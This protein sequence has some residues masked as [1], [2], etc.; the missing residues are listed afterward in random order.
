MSVHAVDHARGNQH[1]QALS[2]AA[3]KVGSHTKAHVP[4]HEPAEIDAPTSGALPDDTAPTA[5]EAEKMPGVVRLLEAGHFKGVADVRLRINF[6]DELSARA[7]AAA[8]PVAQTQSREL[9]DT[10]GTAAN[11]L[12]ETL[13]TDDQTSEALTGL[14]E[15]FDSAVQASVDKFAA[16]GAADSDALAGALQSAFDTLVQG[17]R[18]LLTAPVAETEPVPNPG[19]SEVSA[20]GRTQA[21]VAHAALDAAATADSAKDADDASGQPD[22]AL[23]PAEPGVTADPTDDVVGQPVASLDDALAS[24]TAAFKDALANLL[25]A[26]ETSTRLPDP[27]PPTSNGVA[28]AKFLAQYNELRGPASTVDERG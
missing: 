27:S 13:A 15:E 2:S 22:V 21:V 23:T 11:E 14:L 16:D 12:I 26:L 18:E 24:L 10:V 8:G 17:L 28:Y 5:G 3:H 25:T 19:P 9:V 4:S 20:D 1:L 6:F 7:A